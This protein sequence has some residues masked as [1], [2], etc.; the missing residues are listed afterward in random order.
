MK[1]LYKNDTDF[2]VL[3]S[4]DPF[5]Q[6]QQA[7]LIDMGYKVIEDWEPPVSDGDGDDAPLPA[8]ADDDTEETFT[9]ASGKTVT[10]SELE[11]L[12]KNL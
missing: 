11:T 3:P 10:K 1:V 2:I 4:K 8:P 12:L 5:V 6:T 9:T 7:F